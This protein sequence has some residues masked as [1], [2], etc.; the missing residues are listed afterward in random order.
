MAIKVALLYDWKKYVDAETEVEDSIEHCLGRT[1][2]EEHMADK[3]VVFLGVRFVK[4]KR[5]VEAVSF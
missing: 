5:S 2:K 1:A 3:K 4:G